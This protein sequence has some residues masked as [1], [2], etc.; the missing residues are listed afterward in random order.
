MSPI[1]M[2]SKRFQK[3]EER[4]VNQET[5]I[6]PWPELGLIPMDSPLDPAPSLR[7]E[8]GVVMEMDGKH[9]GTGNAVN[10]FVKAFQVLKDKGYNQWVSLEVFDFTP[11]GKTIAEESM[12]VLKQIEAK[13]A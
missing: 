13:L 1:N 10:D 2:R 8:A 3:L 4:P 11:S 12:K 9:L 7:I 6:K 5:F